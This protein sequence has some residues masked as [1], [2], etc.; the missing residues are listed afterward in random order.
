[1]STTQEEPTLQELMSRMAALEQVNARLLEELTNVRA[2]RAPA[3]VEQANRQSLP[4]TRKSSRRRMLTTGLE[5]AAA[6]VGAGTLL[7]L[8]SGVAS[9]AQPKPGVFAS[10]VAGKPAVS[11]TGT[12]GADGVDASSDSGKGV[13]ATSTSGTALVATTSTGLAGHFVG[14]DVTMD[15]N[16]KVAGELSTGTLSSGAGTFAVAAGTGVQGTSSSGDGVSGTGG[17]HGVVG[18]GGDFGVLGFSSSG[19]GINGATDGGIG[20][21]GFSTQGGTGVQGRSQ[22]GTGVEGSSDSLFGVLGKSDSGTGVSGS[23]SSGAG[24]VGFSNSGAGVR[25]FTGSGTGGLAGEFSGDVLVTG[26]LQV[27][28]VKNFVQDHPTDPTKQIVYTALEGG[29]A[30][31]YTCGTA[32][33]QSGKA[34]IEL[35]EHFGLVTEQAGLTIHLTPRDQWL[36]LYVVELDP[37]Q[38]VVREAQGK[39]GKFDYLIHGRRKGYQHLQVIRTKR[40]AV[41]QD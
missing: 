14:G 25:G 29:E 35:P 19:V 27:T 10:S 33:L 28:G 20:V 24:I 1:M 32:Q 4:R 22:S 11:A 7:E 34:L 41:E 15:N 30:R 36:Q 6:A 26:D 23:S 18:K 5:V 8:S 21:D 12:N 40:E 38:S 37:R 2:E 17:F 31:T 3:A 9:A 13:S 16:L 39:S